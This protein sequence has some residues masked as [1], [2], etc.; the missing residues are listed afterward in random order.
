MPCVRVLHLI[1]CIL[2]GSF[3]WWVQ[4]GEIFP[5]RSDIDEK[6]TAEARAREPMQPADRPV[7]K[8]CDPT[9]PGY[10]VLD[11]IAWGYSDKLEFN[12]T[13][14]DK[15]RFKND[16]ELTKRAKH[17][18]YSGTWYCTVIK[19]IGDKVRPSLSPAI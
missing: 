14:G 1:A 7:D 12:D 11:M 18:V 10:D 6:R 16:A 2:Q 9:Q 8:H 19:V 3:C 4:P 13:E 5:Q 15:A 17:C